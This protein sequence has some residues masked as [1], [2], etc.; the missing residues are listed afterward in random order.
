MKSS[1]RQ[2]QSSHSFTVDQMLNMAS[3]LVDE[4]YGSFERCN[5]VIS[6]TSG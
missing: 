2:S 3:L 6:A 1:L 4:G 5:F